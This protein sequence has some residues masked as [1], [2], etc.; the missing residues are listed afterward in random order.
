MGRV[1]GTAS[2]PQDRPR[3]IS[4]T[5]QITAHFIPQ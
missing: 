5:M 2:S 1:G 3:A 4:T